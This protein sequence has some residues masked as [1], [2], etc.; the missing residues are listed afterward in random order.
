[1]TVLSTER[2]LLRPWQDADLGPYAA[3]NADPAVMAHFP[4]VLTR[5][6]SDASAARIRS[7]FDEHGYGLWAPC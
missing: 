5:A 2:L 6:E 7:H 1:M 3:L 4:A